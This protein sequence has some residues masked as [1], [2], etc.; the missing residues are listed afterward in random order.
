MNVDE[1]SAGMQQRV[2]IAHVLAVDLH[3]L[4]GVRVLI[5]AKIGRIL[6]REYPLG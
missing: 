3:L 5:F 2:R 4:R 6:T 1:P